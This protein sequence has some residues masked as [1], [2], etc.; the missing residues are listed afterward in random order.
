MYAAE[1][2][3]KCYFN[4]LEKHLLKTYPQIEKLLPKEV[5]EDDPFVGDDRLLRYIFAMYDPKSPLL[6]DYP[7]TTS[8]KSA[9]AA[10][11]GFNMKDVGILDKL[12]CCDSDY[13]VGVIVNFL[14][15]IIQSRLWA[16]IVADEQLFWE[17]I[18]RLMK[19]ISEL[20]D[21]DDVNAIEKKM[22]VSEGKESVSSQIESNWTKFLGDDEELKKKVKK[23]NF[24]PEFMAGVQ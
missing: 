8:R 22:K 23:Q 13:M 4:P 14:R 19:P 20:S 9:A 24:S 18:T 5:S 10:I 21:K 15:H 11:A 1:H 3:S 17:F 6:K 2:F 16:S 12:Y 7:D